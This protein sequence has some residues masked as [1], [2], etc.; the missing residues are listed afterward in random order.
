MWI[1]VLVPCL[2][3][4]T[5]T[6][7]AASSPDGRFKISVAKT[8]G[9]LN[10]S[11]VM[12]YLTSDGAKRLV[13]TDSSDR[14]PK[15]VEIVWKEDSTMCAVIV[16]GLWAPDL[17]WV[18]DVRQGK[19]LD[20]TAMKE[21]IR[22]YLVSRYGLQSEAKDPS[23]DPLKWLSDHVLSGNLKIPKNRG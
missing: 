16:S 15:L 20:R 10:E 12:I 7:N 17:V 22:Q 2:F 6:M 1:L 23:F 18:F 5:Q 19:E 11:D 14:Y 9:I 21:T 8:K 13:Y 4:C 3:G